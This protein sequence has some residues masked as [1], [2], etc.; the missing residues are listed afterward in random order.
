MWV[1][2]CSS[3]IKTH[4][5]SPCTTRR[6]KRQRTQASKTPPPVI[7]YRH[8]SRSSIQWLYLRHRFV[9]A[10]L[11]QRHLSDT[12]TETQPAHQFLVESIEHLVGKYQPFWTMHFSILALPPCAL[13]TPFIQSKTPSQLTTPTM[14]YPSIPLLTP[15]NT[16]S[17]ACC[18]FLTKK[19]LIS[20]QTFSALMAKYKQL[21]L[22]LKIMDTLTT[23]LLS[24]SL[25]TSTKY[26]QA[27][28]VQL[29][30]TCR[31][32]PQ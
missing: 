2:G 22:P 16:S 24:R 26:Q 31:S 28:W 12:H 30:N 8:H 11:H 14:I 32:P 13:M 3:P 21:S 23:P 7:H 9:Q 27:I 19:F 10:Y 1:R 5:P 17:E 25:A 29:P 6:S 4:P 15:L 20:A 18:P